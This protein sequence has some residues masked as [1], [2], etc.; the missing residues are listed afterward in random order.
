[1]S[2]PKTTT[3][4]GSLG[5]AGVFLASGT[6][7]SRILG[8]IAAIILARTLG[9]VGSGADAFALANQLPNNIYALVAGGI[10]TAILVPHIVK[11]TSHADGGQAFVNKIVT[12]GLLLFL[13]IAILGTLLAP[14]LVSLYAQE[15]VAGGRGFTS[16]DIALA[17]ALA[18]WCLP[19]VFFYALYSL[20]SEVLNARKVY[21]P[22][23]WAPVMNNIILITGLL[24]FAGVF[25]RVDTSD[26][27]A[28]SPGMVSLLGAS[29][30]A[31]VAGQ[32]LILFAFWKRAGL[33]FRPDFH[34]RGVG[35][36]ATGKA[37]AWMFGMILVTQIAGIFQ[38]NVASLATADGDAGLAILRFS[39]LI[40]MLPH[41]VITVSLATAYFTN[42]SHR[43]KEGQWG[44][45]ADTFVD[46]VRRIG[47]F[48]VLAAVGLIVVAGPFARVFSADP[49]SVDQMALVVVGYALGLLPF[50]MVFVL[51]RV[52]FSL[53]DT[54]T[55][56][57]LQVV[58]AVVF[59]ALVLTVAT[60]P[61]DQI[62]L[63]I[64]V[65]TSLAATVQLLVGLVLLRRR[66][67]G[68]RLRRMLPVFGVFFASALIAALAGVGVLLLVS[69]GAF[70][71]LADA[72]ALGA[73][74]SIVV[75]TLVMTAVY[76]GVLGLTRNREFLDV[77]S[78]SRALVR[79]VL[80]RG[81]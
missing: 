24:V 57:L 18:Y 39:W 17:T 44:L 54:R 72:G 51:Q 40:F 36:G 81:E 77:V 78:G 11:A 71:A 16:D 53:N 33:S 50:T 59:I 29:A 8:F 5:R 34:W 28:W 46:A 70:S 2:D 41:S 64:A 43:A 30:T 13:L 15:G 31:G 22:F 3:G 38:S 58:H 12:I 62:A 56:F 21:G 19:Q 52:F 45:L 68:L 80:K 26:A 7:V 67:R 69:G 32:A 75:I 27:L 49:K 42:M 35:L 76:A 25:H 55:P 23:T 4:D 65:S 74:V 10:L 61:S 66:L 73:G 37:A 20:L 6:V 60:A 47:M 79:R 9:T 48:M 14:V 63:G 1:M